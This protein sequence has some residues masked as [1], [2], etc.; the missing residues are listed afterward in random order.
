MPRRLRRAGPDRVAAG[1]QRRARHGARELDVE[2]VQTDAFSGELVDARRQLTADAAVD[3]DFA[4]TRLSGN[5][6]TMFGRDACA[7]TL[8]GASNPAI[9]ITTARQLRRLMRINI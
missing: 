3:A 5:I 1:H 9:A 4:P 6:R 2:V 7:A 8:L